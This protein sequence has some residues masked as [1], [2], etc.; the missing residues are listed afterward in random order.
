MFKELDLQDVPAVCYQLLLLSSKVSL[1]LLLC[2]SHCIYLIAMNFCCTLY[3]VGKI[4]L[5]SVLIDLFIINN[6]SGMCRLVANNAN[7]SLKS[8]PRYFAKTVDL[9]L[10]SVILLA[11]IFDSQKVL[12]ATVWWTWERLSQSIVLVRRMSD[13]HL[14]QLACGVNSSERSGFDPQL[15]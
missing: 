2:S 5:I 13:I 7:V 10:H 6:F 11:L 9:L 4:V 14:I 12:R 1:S 3:Y 15:R 8:P